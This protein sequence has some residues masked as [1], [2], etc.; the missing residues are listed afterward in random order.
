MCQAHAVGQADQTHL[1]LQLRAAGIDRHGRAGHIGHDGRKRLL[2]A[3]GKAKLG[4]EPRA[5]R[6]EQRGRN[7]ADLRH[8]ARAHR[9]GHRLGIDGVP[10]D[11][12]QAFDRIRDMAAERGDHGCN[13]VAHVA[14]FVLLADR[15]RGHRG[16]RA[17]R[18][19]VLGRQVFVQSAADNG[20]EDIVDLA[21][22]RQGA[23]GLDVG[24]RY[25]HPL[26]DAVR[27]N[28]PVEPAA[29]RDE[30]ARNLEILRGQAL[31]SIRQPRR[32]ARRHIQLLHRIGQR[33]EIA[34]A[35]KFRRIGYLLRLPGVRRIGR[36]LVRV[37]RVHRFQ[38]IDTAHPVDCG[39]MHLGHHRK[40]A[41]RHAVDVF[42]PFDD[43]EFPRRPRQVERTGEYPCR[44]NAKLAPVA[45]LGQGQVADMIF[46][47]EIR[48]LYPIGII[49]VE[50]D[51]YQTLADSPRQ[52]HPAFEEG[53][54]VLEPDE[55][56][57]GR[58]RIVNQDRT[59]MHR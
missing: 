24:Q 45:R 31:D 50:R 49:E 35:E 8:V 28:L 7:L 38:Q 40:A 13:L 9:I 51:T 34:F 20:E 53:Q 2:D 48:V 27:R 25:A 12:F 14:F 18:Q 47:I 55:T 4:I 46:Q 32:G 6:H 5:Q 11:V 10:M 37:E 15:D 54:N 52:L 44:L 57:R 17:F 30:I 42:Q 29:R 22:G 21:S 56:A 43:R 39:V 23:D 41:G 19:I 36:G 16:E 1:A 26:N 59:D 58:S 33:V 3:L